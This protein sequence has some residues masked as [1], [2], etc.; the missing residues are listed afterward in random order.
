MPNKNLGLTGVLIIIG[1]CIFLT[2]LALSHLPQETENKEGKC[3]NNRGWTN[4]RHLQRPDNASLFGILR[5]D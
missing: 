3:E 1:N 2:G 4:L 5:H